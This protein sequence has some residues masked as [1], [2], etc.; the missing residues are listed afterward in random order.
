MKV[1]ICEDK[2]TPIRVHLK[3]GDV[4]FSEEK[5]RELV[6]MLTIVLRKLNKETLDTLV[7]VNK[8][9]NIIKE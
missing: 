4:Y 3:I 2:K 8:L 7:M 5:A 6:A 1:T 9:H